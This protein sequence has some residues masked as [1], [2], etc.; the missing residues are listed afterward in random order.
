M[1]SELTDTFSSSAEQKAKT[2]LSHLVL[3]LYKSHAIRHTVGRTSLTA[4]N[5][6]RTSN[7]HKT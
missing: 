4:Q 3:M 5:K 7:A 2:S 6:Q 1:T